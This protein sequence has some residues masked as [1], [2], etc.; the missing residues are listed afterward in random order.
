[1]KT[2]TTVAVSNY[3]IHL[4]YMN[5]LKPIVPNVDAVMYVVFYV[6]VVIASSNVCDININAFG[7][8]DNSFYKHVFIQK[9]CTS[10]A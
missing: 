5:I 8:Y 10:S 2:K 6:I 3:C 7:N 4:Y 9:C 1:M